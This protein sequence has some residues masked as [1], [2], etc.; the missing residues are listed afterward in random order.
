VEEVPETITSLEQEQLPNNHME[1]KTLI[2]FNMKTKK[3]KKQ[4]HNLNPADMSS[5]GIRTHS[6]KGKKCLVY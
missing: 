6:K 2:L 1:T 3:K 4:S 5:D